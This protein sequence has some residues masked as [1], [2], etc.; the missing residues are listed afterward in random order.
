MFKYQASDLNHLFKNR[1]YEEELMDD[2]AASGPVI[3]QTLRE[4]EIINQRLGGNHVTTTG[5]EKLLR[6]NESPRLHIADLGC[7]G[8]D[9]LK[10]IAKWAEKRGYECE[11]DGYDANPNIIDYAK[12]NCESYQNISFETKDIFSEEFKQKR[13]DIILCTLFTHHFHE[14]QLTKIFR[15]FKNQAEIGVIINDLHRHWLAYYS[16][17]LLTQLFSKSEMVKFDGPLSVRRAFRRKELISIMKRAEITN[18]RI[19]W[20]WAFRWQLIF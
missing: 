11:L 16:I 1:S 5:L 2:L 20:M 18:F 13:F 19:K 9:I 8:G 7:G 4:L 12:G 10:L 14:D 17:K 3:P 15:Q 6:K